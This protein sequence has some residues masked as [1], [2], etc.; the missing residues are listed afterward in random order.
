MIDAPRGLSTAI[1]IYGTD[2][3][4]LPNTDGVFKNYGLTDANYGFLSAITDRWHTV[5]V[6]ELNFFSNFHSLHISVEHVQMTMKIAT[7]FE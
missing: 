1:W 3:P 7:I 4:K 2:L 6:A 5:R